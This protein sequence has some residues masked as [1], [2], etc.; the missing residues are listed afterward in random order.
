[1]ALL[2]SLIFILFLWQSHAYSGGRRTYTDQEFQQAI[3]D[4]TAAKEKFQSIG[5][6]SYAFSEQQSCFCLWCW[7]APKYIVIE[8]DTAIHVEYHS[9]EQTCGD[10]D[11]QKP[12]ADNYEPIDAYFDR[13]IAHAQKGLDA[14]CIAEPM[15]SIHQDAICGGRITIEFDDALSYPTYISLQYGPFIADAGV[16]MLPLC[17]HTHL[18]IIGHDTI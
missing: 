8:D 7:I 16:C 18:C 9:D 5:I 13:A 15:P 17:T 4:I 2:S 14:G 6:T 12:I 3:D 10:A 1:M 11:I